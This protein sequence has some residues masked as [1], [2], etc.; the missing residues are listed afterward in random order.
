[1]S[2]ILGWLAIAFVAILIA[3][4]ILDF[5]MSCRDAMTAASNAADAQDQARGEWKKHK[6]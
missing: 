5:A 2:R 4:G 1:M 6:P 3:R